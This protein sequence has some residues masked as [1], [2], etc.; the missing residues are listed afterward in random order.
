MQV[1]SPPLRD[2]FLNKPKPKS[3]ERQQTPYKDEVL[4]EMRI[5]ELNPY[6]NVKVRRVPSYDERVRLGAEMDNG[7]VGRPLSM[8]DLHVSAEDAKMAKMLEEIEHLLLNSG[9]DRVTQRIST[10]SRSHNPLKLVKD[11]LDPRKTQNK[12]DSKKR[13]RISSS[14][15]KGDKKRRTRSAW[16]SIRDTSKTPTPRSNGLT[17]SDIERLTRSNSE[18]NR[19]LH[20]SDLDTPKSKSISK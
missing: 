6:A 13:G 7:W 1:R 4:G 18:R 9:N 16:S 10:S 14:P 3:Q 19:S 11:R 20:L 5:G 12:R 2:F 8:S 15:S 17:A